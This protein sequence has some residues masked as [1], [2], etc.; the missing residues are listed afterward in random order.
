MSETF[1]SKKNEKIH[2]FDLRFLK[3]Y[4]Q[5]VREIGIKW[6]VIW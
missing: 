5:N 1:V 4:P 6:K 2:S 3:G